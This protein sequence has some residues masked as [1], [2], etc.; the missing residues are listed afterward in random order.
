M[1]R[2]ILSAAAA[3]LAL[4]L[5]MPSVAA[6]V[7]EGDLAGGRFSQSFAAP[8]ELG[9]GVTGVRGTGSGGR[10]DFFVFTGLRPGA[11]TLTFTFS[12]PDDIGWSYIAGGTIMAST[13]PFRWGWDGVNAGS[14]I[15]GLWQPDVTRTVRLT[16]AFRG[17]LYVGLY[18]WGRDLSYDVRLDAAPLPD[19]PV[20]VVPVPGAGALLLTALGAAGLAVRLRRT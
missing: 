1:N 4:G 9:A 10:D 14:F 18:F 11:Q 2:I 8:T 20:S 7:H 16:E 5:S 19:E 15:V 13:S 17:T 6:T 12:A 3:L